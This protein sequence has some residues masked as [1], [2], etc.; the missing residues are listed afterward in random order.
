[1]VDDIFW[2]RMAL[3]ISDFCRITVDSSNNYVM[4]NIGKSIDTDLEWC[5]QE[6]ILFLA[7]RCVALENN[8]SDLQSDIAEIDFQRRILEKKI[9][10]DH[11]HTSNKIRSRYDTI[12]YNQ[13]N[14]VPNLHS[15]KKYRQ[16]SPS[17]RDTPNRSFQSPQQDLSRFYHLNGS[18]SET[19]TETETETESS[20]DSLK[21]FRTFQSLPVS[22]V[23]SV[24]SAVSNISYTSPDAQEEVPDRQSPEITLQPFW[25]IGNLSL[26]CKHI[27]QKESSRHHWDTCSVSSRESP[28]TLT[29]NEIYPSTAAEETV[30]T[31]LKLER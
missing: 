21:G 16:T 25:K 6:A 10:E 28:P 3:A 2:L 5:G 13:H 8:V 30:D 1:M 11:S 4:S 22:S 17:Q 29:L 26:P 7:A 27:A 20:E 19:E 15:F 14:L 23:S 18:E 9:I 12:L 31:L 24:S